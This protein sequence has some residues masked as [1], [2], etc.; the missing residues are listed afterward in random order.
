MSSNDTPNNSFQDLIE[1]IDGPYDM[2]A[3]KARMNRVFE[4][5]SSLFPRDQALELEDTYGINEEDVQLIKERWGREWS[6]RMILRLVAAENRRVSTDRMY[7]WIVQQSRNMHYG[8]P[9]PQTPTPPES[10]AFSWESSPVL[11]E[12][13]VDPEM[14][15]AEQLRYQWAHYRIAPGDQ[16]SRY[17]W[18]VVPT[19]DEENRYKACRQYN[20][21]HKRVYGYTLNFWEVVHGRR[22]QTQA[23]NGLNPA[24]PSWAPYQNNVVSQPLY[25]RDAFLS[26]HAISGEDFLALAR[27]GQRSA[28]DVQGT[29]TPLIPAH[30]LSP[31]ITF[32]QQEEEAEYTS[33]GD[34]NDLRLAPR[35][36]VFNPEENALHFGELRFSRDQPAGEVTQSTEEV[37]VGEAEPAE[38]TVQDE[39]N[40]E[41]A[42]EEP[43]ESTQGTGRT[44]TNVQAGQSMSLNAMFGIAGPGYNEGGEGRGGRVARAGRGRRDGKR[45]WA[46]IVRSRKS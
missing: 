34:W 38:E 41:V 20:T 42:K 19:M 35:N 44:D 9:E 29:Q 18:R 6:T 17:F 24:A 21:W 37:E 22:I 27:E 25:T 39:G 13:P 8:Y 15:T 23:P 28:A 30:D 43:A 5:C 4:P 2:L 31:R 33:Q 14:P 12:D 1:N 32:G 16:F 36:Q 11:P 7:D 3:R 10:V 46:D 26:G 45:S 40:D